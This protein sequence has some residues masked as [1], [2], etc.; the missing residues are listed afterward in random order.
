M[1]PRNFRLKG[2][3]LCDAILRLCRL[4]SDHYGPDLERFL[5][6]LAV[7]S[8]GASRFQRD[9][10]MRARYADQEPLPEGYRTPVSRRAIAESV[11]LPRETV[12]RKIAALIADG[13]LVEVGNLVMARTPVV[14]Q[15][16]NLEF[17]VAALKAFEWAS[18]ELSRAE[19]V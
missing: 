12:R 4:A 1:P 3:V 15:G 9:P 14:E 6:Y 2:I 10:E 13:H 18:A 7:I 11:G 5:V 8:A 17:L 19:R 16:R